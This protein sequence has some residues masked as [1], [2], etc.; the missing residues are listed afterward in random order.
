MILRN[1]GYL[2]KRSEFPG[3]HDC[4]TSVST[5]YNEVSKDQFYLVQAVVMT[6]TKRQDAMQKFLM[7]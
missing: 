6:E 2:N 3:K 7:Q 4:C 5:S 1:T